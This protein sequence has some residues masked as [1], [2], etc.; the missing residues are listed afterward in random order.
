MFKIL[1]PAEVQIFEESKLTGGKLSRNSCSITQ[2][3]FCH[4]LKTN[5]P[6]EGE[7]SLKV[8]YNY[9]KIVPE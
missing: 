3:L 8:K 2:V 4:K 7:V 1:T 9:F 6:F 5:G